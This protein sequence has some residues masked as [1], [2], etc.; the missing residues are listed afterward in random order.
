MATPSITESQFVGEVRDFMRDFPELNRL[1]SGEESSDRMIRFAMYLAVD[2]WNVMPPLTGHTFSNFPSR[3]MLL[4]LTVIHLLTSVGILKS[5]NSFAYSDGGFTVQTEEHD[6]RY[7]R[8]IQLF[9]SAGPAS[10]KSMRDLKIAM[11]IAGGWGTSV[12]SEY[13]WIHGWYGLT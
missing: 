8:W 1:I 5:R 4:Y 10:F 9:R 11:N 12:G 6:T 3:G 13:G 7:Q 2:E